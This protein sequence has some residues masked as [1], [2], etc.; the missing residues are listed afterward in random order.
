MQEYLVRY[1]TA[2]AC[3]D[4]DLDKLTRGLG[5]ERV[6]PVAVSVSEI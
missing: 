6:P 1:E 2:E 3:Y 4:F 5:D